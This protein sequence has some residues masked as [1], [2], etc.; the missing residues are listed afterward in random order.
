M[1][2]RLQK[3]ISQAGIASRREAEKL[4]AEGRVAVDGKTVTEQGIKID[5][6]HHKITVNGK[7]IKG[8][9]QSVYFLLNKPKG[10]LSTVKDDR[11]RK[12]VI[13]LLPE[14]RERIFPVGR[15]DYN[16]EGLLLLTNDGQLMNALIHPRGEIEKTYIASVSGEI[17]A[18]KLERLRNGVELEDGLT[19]PAKVR[20]LDNDPK[21]G[22]TKIEVIIHEGRNRQVR[23][24]FSAVGCE[25]KGLK[26]SEFA[27]LNLSGVKRG[28]Y[29]ALSDEE[30]LYLQSLAGT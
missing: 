19:A 23:R 24:M 3:I 27:G 6:Q 29:R 12:T 7:E 20:V 25:V 5:P 30:L 16:T 8:N 4:I 26:R 15:L 21:T 17:T 11:G 14:V 22:K 1:E 9:E 10:Y 13:D 18:E 2:E 28:E